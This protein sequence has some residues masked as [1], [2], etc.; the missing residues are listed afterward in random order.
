M[1]QYGVMRRLQEH[2]EEGYPNSGPGMV[3]V[4]DA[5]LPSI[6]VTPDLQTVNEHVVAK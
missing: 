1:N 3:D 5:S 4:V 2:V 6:V